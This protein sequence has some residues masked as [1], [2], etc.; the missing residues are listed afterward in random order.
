[1]ISNKELLEIVIS[2]VF[3]LL[4]QKNL[5]E[6]ERCLSLKKS[7]RK[8][9]TV[10]DVPRMETTDWLLLMDVFL[11]NR[12][13]SVSRL[14]MEMSFGFSSSRKFGPSFMVITAEL[15]EVFPTRHSEI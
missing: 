11:A 10:L 2:L 8:T 9:C 13:E 5:I 14:L 12:K 15:L 1:M 6:L 4:W 3:W 7:C